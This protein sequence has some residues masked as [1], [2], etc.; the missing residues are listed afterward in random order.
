MF[1]CRYILVDHKLT[2]NTEYVSDTV[3]E[4]L[5]EAK[6][7]VEEESGP[8]SKK[9]KLKG[10][11]KQRPKGQ[12]IVDEDKLCPSYL[13]DKTCIFGD[14]CK[15]S[16]NK[17][18]FMANKPADIGE[19]CYLFETYGKCPYGLACRFGKLHISDDL[20]NVVSED[21]DK[22]PEREKTIMNLLTKDLQHSLWKRKYDY[23]KAEKVLKQI[24]P[25]WVDKWGRKDK[26]SG[27]IG[28]KDNQ[29]NVK[30]KSNDVNEKLDNTSTGE[31]ILNSDSTK[32]DKGLDSNSASVEQ[33]G[34]GECSSNTE[35]SV[36]NNAVSGDKAAD[37]MEV[38]GSV[39]Q[40]NGENKGS[41]PA[42]IAD[43]ADWTMAD[44]PP[45]VKKIVSFSD[46]EL[47]FTVK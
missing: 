22:K 29:G 28:L 46:T 17:A 16:H 33:L 1:F 40:C 19:K 6:K 23:S 7:E 11:N 39:S 43:N 12:K 26:K 32:V 35:S 25:G 10:R 44:F 31:S 14:K 8:P 42:G 45:K 9:I 4:K 27:N 38:S 18:K 41:E 13:S 15:F 5:D 37:E 21:V 24:C 36:K 2:V 34:Q 47:L 3:K 20:K 30:A